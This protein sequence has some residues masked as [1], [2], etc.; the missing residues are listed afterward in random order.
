MEYKEVLDVVVSTGMAR[1]K[2]KGSDG[3]TR[4]VRMFRFVQNDVPRVAVAVAGRKRHGIPADADGHFCRDWVSV[5]PA[6]EATDYVKRIVKRARMA[7]SMLDGS[8]LWASIKAEIDEF[9]RLPI[10]EVEE[11]VEAAC[12]DF[13]KNVYCARHD[14]KFKWC[15]T[16]QIFESFLSDK[17]W[18]S[19]KFNFAC[20]AEKSALA[21]A[22]RDGRNY[23]FAWRDGYDNSVEVSFSDDEARGWYSEEYKGCGNGHYYLL[24]DATHAIFYED[25]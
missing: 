20:E 13:Y 21:Q 14:G 1:Y 17:C 6:E 9:L 12:S 22:I 4:I 18:K 5:K 10:E 15:R 8:G 16:Y 25:D 23:R 11:F 3:R 7:Q 19:P 24:F 2:V